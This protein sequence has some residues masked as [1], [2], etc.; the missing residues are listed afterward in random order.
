MA[1]PNTCP[2]DTMRPGEGGGRARDQILEGSQGRV[3]SFA[4]EVACDFSM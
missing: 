3:E 4:V 1:P 2:D